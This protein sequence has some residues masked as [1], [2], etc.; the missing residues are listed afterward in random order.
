MVDLALPIL[1][2][3]NTEHALIVEMKASIARLTAEVARLK[4][5]F[6]EDFQLPKNAA[7]DSGV[8]RQTLEKWVELGKV[9]HF[10]DDHGQLWICVI[11]AIRQRY[12]LPPGSGKNGH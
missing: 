10:Y 12:G 2:P 11:D 5:P 8:P 3:V 7:K 9:K 4:E 6:A 1:E